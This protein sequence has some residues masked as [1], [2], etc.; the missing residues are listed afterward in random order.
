MLPSLI[1]L[2]PTMHELE[3]RTQIRNPMLDSRSNPVRFSS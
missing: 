1:H 2:K 3:F